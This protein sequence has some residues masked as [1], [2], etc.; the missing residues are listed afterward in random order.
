MAGAVWY[1]SMQLSNHICLIKCPKT[2]VIRLKGRR[3]WEAFRESAKARPFARQIKWTN[4]RLSFSSFF[5]N[6]FQKITSRSHFL[7]QNPLR[8]DLATFSGFKITSSE[9]GLLLFLFE[10]GMSKA[11]DLKTR[12][13]TILDPFDH[14]NAQPKL[15]VHP[16][17]ELV[18]F[19]QLRNGEWH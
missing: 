12:R 4:S 8:E 6:T 16:Y 18:E 10:T 11:L 9:K 13:S 19:S 3:L 17:V 2:S 5:F 14:P 15:L 7:V 1:I